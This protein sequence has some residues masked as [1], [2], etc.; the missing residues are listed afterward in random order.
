MALLATNTL[1]GYI[2]RG[3]HI[4]RRNTRLRFSNSDVVY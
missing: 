3:V 1:S 4:V 2:F